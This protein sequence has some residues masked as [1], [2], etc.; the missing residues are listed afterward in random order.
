[1]K[2]KSALAFWISLA[3][4]IAA[5][6]LVAVKLAKKFSKKKAEP[7]EEQDD[8]PIGSLIFARLYSRKNGVPAVFL[9]RKEDIRWVNTEETASMKRCRRK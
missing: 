8:E 9:F 6:A 1:M 4:V 3:L 5:V 7:E 2:K